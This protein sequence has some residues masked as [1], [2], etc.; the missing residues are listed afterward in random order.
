[1]SST[2]E[3]VARPRT[4]TKQRVT[5]VVPADAGPQVLAFADQVRILLGGAFIVRLETDD[6]ITPAETR[7]NELPFVLQI[8]G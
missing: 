7:L 5:L 3:S 2:N 4:R 6:E 8:L 1:M